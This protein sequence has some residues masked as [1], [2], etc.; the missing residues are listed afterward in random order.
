MPPQSSV[1]IGFYDSALTFKTVIAFRIDIAYD[2][3]INFEHDWN[4]YFQTAA[5]L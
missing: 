5:I 4:I 1:V 3:K 2:K